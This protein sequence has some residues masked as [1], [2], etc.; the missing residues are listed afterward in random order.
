MAIITA[1]DVEKDSFIPKNPRWEQ[2]LKN[3]ATTW[4]AKFIHTDRSM[5]IKPAALDRAD[6]QFSEYVKMKSA[7]A[8]NLKEKAVTGAGASTGSAL[9]GEE[10]LQL[11]VDDIAME[12]GGVFRGA[13]VSV[14]PNAYGQV[15]KQ[16]AGSVGDFVPMNSGTTVTNDVSPTFENLPVDVSGYLAMIQIYNDPVLDSYVAQPAQLL[17]VFETVL[18]L[19]KLW[20]E[21]KLMSAS[22][23]NAT[24]GNKTA[25]AASSATEF[26]IAESLYK[27]IFEIRKVS[28][29]QPALFLSA[30]GLTA[31]LNE[32]DANGNFSNRNITFMFSSRD[33][34]IPQ[35]GRVGTFGG[36]GVFI[37]ESILSTYTVNASN[38]VTAQ[39]AGSHTVGAVMAPN[40]GLIAR[41]RGDLDYTQVFSGRTGDLTAFKDGLTIVG[42]ET[43]MGAGVTN[44]FLTGYY[45]FEV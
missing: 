36:V 42:A 30:A 15:T 37:T 10:F 3:F 8:Q 43:H 24:L 44:G 4:N 6:N 26:P 31:L 33:Q 32:R 21:D 38:V 40:A 35:A 7:I 45:A 23:T 28:A 17:G 11:V 25:I 5:L 27:L 19:R 41:G 13:G 34:S 29:R 39:T 1:T 9:V 14:R 20:H 18:E 12:M 2:K 16:G 22:I